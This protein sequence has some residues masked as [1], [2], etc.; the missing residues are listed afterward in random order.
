MEMVRGKDSLRKKLLEK[1]LSLTRDEIERRSIDV[2]RNLSGV[3][4]YKKAKV[5]MAYYPLKGEVDIR[6][7][8]KKAMEEKR[9]CFPV[10]NVENRQLIP[11]MVKDLERD[12]RKG[13]YGVMQ[14]DKERTVRVQHSE[15]DVVITP[16]LAFAQDKNRL[17][18][19]AGYYDRFL[20]G[21]TGKTT[22]IGVAFD[23]QVVSCLPASPSYDVKVDIL[24]TET[25][26]L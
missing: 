20:K 1:L 18:R 25:R 22:I 13:P 19:G 8:L 12:F 3:A 16:G 11:Y 4:L 7:L 5:I 10:I 2:A 24:V 26:I 17:G 15:I 9:V 21:L 23:F 14:P 6:E